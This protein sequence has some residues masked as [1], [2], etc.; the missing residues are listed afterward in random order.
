[1]DTVLASCGTGSCWP[2]TTFEGCAEC[3]TEQL[4]NKPEAFQRMLYD[5]AA[6][7]LF[8]ATGRQFGACP[9]T[10]RPCAENCDCCPGWWGGGLPVPVK[11]WDGEWVNLSCN[12]CA[13]R[14]ECSQVSEVIIPD[15]DQVLSV[16]IDG[17]DYDPCDTVAVY[18]RRRI[19]RTDGDEWP[20]CQDLNLI[21]GPGTWS[22]TVLQGR[23]VP[24][25]GDWIASLLACELGK[26]C[27][28]AD[29][30]RLPQRV[31]TIT[32]QG[33]T[34]GF[35][36]QFDNLGAM[37]TGIW[38]IDAWIESAVTTVHAT[39]AVISPD[40]NWRH[41]RLTWPRDCDCGSQRSV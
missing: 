15:T 24:P 35:Q 41:T 21:D 27:T 13:D 12:R 14:C 16:R 20:K 6:Q 1:M 19:V 11:R 8:N 28:D 31:Q 3:C 5:M 4:L 37:R 26:A 18:D 40:V 9:V 38:E 34:I 23:P 25:G 10:Y 32:R 36:D 2:V 22:I 39:P 17:V 33:V 29:G 7:F 30:C